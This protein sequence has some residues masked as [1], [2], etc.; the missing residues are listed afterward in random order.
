MSDVMQLL[1]QLPPDDRILRRDS[2]EGETHF[3]DA[4]DDYAEAVVGDTRMVEMAKARIKRIEARI[5]RNR[6]IVQRIL[7]IAD[8]DSAERPLYTVTLT[9]HRELQITSEAEIPDAYW[10]HAPDKIAIAKALR[11]GS[12]VPGAILGNTQPR[13]TILAKEQMV[14]ENEG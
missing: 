10:R 8:L 12:D 14:E 2:L 3:F 1:E 4:L 5:E 6:N 11:A 9:H 7:Q 13:L